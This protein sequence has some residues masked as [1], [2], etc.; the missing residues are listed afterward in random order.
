[1]KLSLDPWIDFMTSKDI[2]QLFA[3]DVIKESAINYGVFMIRIAPWIWDFYRK[4][5]NMC[6]C[7]WSRMH[8]WP[9]EQVRA[10]HPR[11]PAPFP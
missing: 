4:M 7:D 9:A 11:P 1:M 5:Y 3:S 2:D 6:T 10:R 8:D